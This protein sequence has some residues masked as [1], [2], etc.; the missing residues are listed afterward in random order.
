MSIEEI[1][2]DVVLKMSADWHRAFNTAG[3]NPMCHGCGEWIKVDDDFKL[4]VVNTNRR[5]VGGSSYVTGSLVSRDVML[6]AKCTPES[7]ETASKEAIE[8]I[9]VRQSRGGGCYRVNGKFVH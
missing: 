8:R 9:E 6:C 3:C 4:A 7:V 1:P 2:A 5:G